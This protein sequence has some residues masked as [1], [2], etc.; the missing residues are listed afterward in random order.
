MKKRKLHFL[1]LGMLF[2]GIS[3]LLLNC[4]DENSI[5][6]DQNDVIEQVNDFQPIEIEEA[7]NL[8]NSI[9]TKNKK[10]SKKN[11]FSVTIDKKSLHFNEVKNTYLSI[12]TFS[13]SIKSDIHSTVFMVKKQG[14]IYPCL[15][16]Y[17]PN[18]NNSSE[19]TI[20][21]ST[22][23]GEFINGYKV[24]DGVFVSQYK[25]KTNSKNAAKTYAKRISTQY[26]WDLGELD[27]IEITRKGAGGGKSSLYFNT[28]YHPVSSQGWMSLNLAGG[29]SNRGG[30]RSNGGKSNRKKYHYS[31]VIVQ[32]LEGVNVLRVKSKMLQ[33]SV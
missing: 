30:G 13:A 9:V 29:R 4:I 32:P 12:P 33:E 1:K 27:A 26:W 21:V 16:N 3:L 19:G 8:L 11:G 28:N 10:H 5:G 22:I 2:F 25:Q 17:I 20:I 24:V 14:V 31:L 18:K 7:K 6:L 15:Y 23:D